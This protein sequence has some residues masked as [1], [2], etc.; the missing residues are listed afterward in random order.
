ERLDGVDAAFHLL[1]VREAIFGAAELLELRDVGAGD[2]RL[3]A[4]S[5]KDGN[6]HIVLGT[7]ARARCVEL[8]V[9]LPGH[10]IVCRRA[11]EDHSRD[12]AGAAVAHFSVAHCAL[13]GSAGHTTP[14]CRAFYPTVMRGLI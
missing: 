7:D 13:I 6:A 9:H 12:L 8:L 4:R 10:G 1:C 14:S 2:E 3:A 5:P 11:I